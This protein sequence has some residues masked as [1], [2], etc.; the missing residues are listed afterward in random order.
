MNIISN[1]KV[2]YEVI[3]R[4]IISKYINKYISRSRSMSLISISMISIIG[5]YIIE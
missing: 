3:I 4:D 5:V 1:Y 2:Y